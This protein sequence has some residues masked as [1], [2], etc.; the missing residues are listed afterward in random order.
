MQTI[1]TDSEDYADM[2]D[3]IMSGGRVDTQL[4]SHIDKAE[5]IAEMWAP[6][7]RAMTNASIAIAH[8]AIGAQ[9]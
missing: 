6:R 4:G 1:H 9:A 2:M 7:A 5:L 3:F 8:A